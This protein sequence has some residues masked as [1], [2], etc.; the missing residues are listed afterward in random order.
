MVKRMCEF[1]G[2]NYASVLGF[3]EN[4]MDKE[5]RI[6]LKEDKIYDAYKK[7]MVKKGNEPESLLGFMTCITDDRYLF[8]MY[9]IVTDTLY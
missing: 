1:M 9:S 3:L 7:F 4:I 8:D 2:L 6:I 5:K